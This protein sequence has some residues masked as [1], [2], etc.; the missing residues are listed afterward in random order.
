MWERLDKVMGTMDWFEKCLAIKVKILE[1]GSLDHKPLI[2]HPCGIPM[3]INK[4][5]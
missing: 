4:P 2:I 3:R 5:W 1:C